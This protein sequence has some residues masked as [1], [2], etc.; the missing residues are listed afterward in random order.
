M[1]AKC[2]DAIVILSGTNNVPQDSVGTTI[3]KINNQVKAARAQ[4]RDAHILLSEIP[5][6]FDNI[7]LNEKIDK[8]NIS[9]SHACSKSD[10]LHVLKHHNMFRS[11]F[12]TDGLHSSLAGRQEFAATVKQS[13]QKIF[14]T[15]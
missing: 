9:I 1:I 7:A 5:I 3:T 6:P 12:G 4:N 15:K 2:D 10:R 8:I 14:G 13:L 11:D